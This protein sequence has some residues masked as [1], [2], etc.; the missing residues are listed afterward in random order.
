MYSHLTREQRS[1]IFALLQRK[2]KKKI[3]ADIVGVS[4]STIYREIKRNSTVKG[5]YLWSQAHEKAISRRYR[6]N[7]RK[8]LEP[9]LVRRITYMIADEQWS[10]R[11]I[12]GV[13][14]KEKIRVSHQTIYNI[15]KNDKTGELAKNTRH[16]MK[17]HRRPKGGKPMPIANRTSIHDRPIE[18][19]GK[20]FGDWEMDLIVDN[21]GHAIVTLV[22]RSVGFMMLE[23]LK[24]GKKAKHLAQVVNRLLFPYRNFVHTITT[25]NGPEFAAHIDLTRKLKATVYFAD[26]YSSWQKGCIEYTNKLVRQYI[27]KGCNF[28][29]FSDA[30]IRKIQFKLNRRPREKLNFSSPKVEFFKHFY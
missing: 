14:N 1:Q 13:L 22:E 29:S 21:Y 7:S 19:N 2:T 25:D 11:Q 17:Y 24:H 30:F 23:K 4:V 3:I 28:N 12:C 26:P 6:A 16:K 10:A 5:H 18:A 15:I 9:I 27:P 20:R 8:A